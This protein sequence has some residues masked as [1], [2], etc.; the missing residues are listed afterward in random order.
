MAEGY[1]IKWY[2]KEVFKIATKVSV[3]AMDAAGAI[4]QRYV[5]EHFTRQGTYQ[6][7]GRGKNRSHW[8]GAP[9]EP[10][11]IDLGNLRAS[12]SHNVET[13]N[14]QITG[15]VFPAIDYLAA[16]ATSGTDV[17]YGYYL[18]YGTSRIKPRPF[19]RPALNAC[20]NKIKSIFQKAIR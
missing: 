8:S 3:D 14:E 10:P 12:I 19:L 5:K 11:A 2:G 17:E 15:K 20:R 18:E 7:Y 4:V 6:K 1:G 13:K 16:K 9:G